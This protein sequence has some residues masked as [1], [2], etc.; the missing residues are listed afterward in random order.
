MIEAR[1]IK[2]PLAPAELD[3]PAWGAASALEIGRY[4][5]G[6]PAPASRHAEAR[7]LWTDAALVVRF[8]CRQEEPLVVSERP[9][10]DQKTLG[11]W[12]RD[13]CEIFVAP[14]T[15]EPENYFEFEVAPTGEWLDL[16]LRQ[17]TAGRVT[18]W[19]YH[20]GMSVAARITPGEI[21]SAMSIPFR[22]LGGRPRAG[23]G[24]RANLYRC[25][26]ADPNRG[27]LA[28]RPT[29]TP[30]PNFH[31]PRQFGPLLFSDEGAG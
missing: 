26:G 31:V 15:G 7:V 21:T 2:H 27:Y 9:R 13:V 25:V 11:L 24:W 30:E 14:H 22:A 17:T 18:D 28:W 20:S 5:S 10:L 4:W 3:H 1:Y 12:D 23:D 19:D 16:A 8:V 29:L 6:E